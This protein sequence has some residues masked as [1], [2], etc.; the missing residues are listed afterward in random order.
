MSLIVTGTVG[1]DTVYTPHEGHREGVLGGS[2]TYFAAA[3]SFY[4][5][6]RIV[7]AVGDDFPDELRATLDSFPEIDTAGLEVRV[8]SKTFRWG[9]KYAENMDTRETLFT[10][11]G[12]LEEMPPKIPDA[13]RDSRFVFLANT[14]PA[15]QLEML[16]SFPE[17]A[18]VVA[19]TMDLWIDTAREELHEL[20]TRVDGLVLNFDEAEQFTGRRNTVSAARRILELGP[21]FVVVKKGEHGCIFVH[22]DGIAALPAYPAERVVD[23]TGAGDSFAGG[24]MGFIAAEAARGA[25]DEPAS[26]ETI[27]RALAHGTVIASFNI[28]SFS[29]D[30]LTTLTREDVVERYGEFIKMVRVD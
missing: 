19:D 17:R 30:R 16:A 22:R 7:G 6:V 12:V 3:A 24:M 26:F 10:E 18:L 1:I 9:G 13:Y 14:H 4:G 5:P 11:L 27:R 25:Q 20:L 23:P 29:L 15:V 2:C 8:G 28:E 21:R